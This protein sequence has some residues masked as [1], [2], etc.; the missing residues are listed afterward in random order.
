MDSTYPFSHAHKGNADSCPCV[1]IDAF[2]VLIPADAVQGFPRHGR[3]KLHPGKPL[4]G[5][6]PFA[7]AQ[8]QTA[9][10]AACV[11]RAG[12][13][14]AYAGCVFSRIEQGRVAPRSM[15]AAEESCA[16]AP[17]ATACNGIAVFDDKI[18]AV[19]DELGV[20]A[21]DRTRP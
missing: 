7:K 18:G 8:H 9:E 17:S 15:I 14:R 20:E 1:G 3:R 6:R 2:D 11:S 13:H 5:R 10:A 16:A 12:V 19:V 4:G 21:H